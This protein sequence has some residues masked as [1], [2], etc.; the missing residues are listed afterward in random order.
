MVRTYGYW[1]YEAWAELIGR[2]AV[3]FPQL[4]GLAIDD[5]A[6]DNIN[7]SIAGLSSKNPGDHRKI[8]TPDLIAR[9]TSNLH[10]H[11]PRISFAP[12]VYYGFSHPLFTQMPDLALSLDAMFYWFRNE[13]QGA[14]PCAW[15]ERSCTII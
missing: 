2:L 15:G 9:I 5:F 11:S 8:F 7:P 13:K 1:D 14:G 12:V 3:Q 4:V 10:R 6:P